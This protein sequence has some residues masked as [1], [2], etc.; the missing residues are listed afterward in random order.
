[1]YL[2]PLNNLKCL[3]V[4]YTLQLDFFLTEPLEF[5]FP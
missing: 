4:G 3:S 2:G 5:E 1:M